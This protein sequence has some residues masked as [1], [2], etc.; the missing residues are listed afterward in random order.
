MSIHFTLSSNTRLNNW[1]PEL[2]ISALGELEANIWN[3]F[4]RNEMNDIF[5]RALACTCT[6]KSPWGQVMNKFSQEQEAEAQILSP[7][8]ALPRPPWR[9]LVL[10]C[11]GDTICWAPPLQ[12]KEQ[13]A[14]GLLCPPGWQSP[15]AGS[16][17]GAWGAQPP[18]ALSPVMQG[19]TQPCSPH[20]Q[21]GALATFATEEMSPWRLFLLAVA[22]LE[23][24]T[25]RRGWGMEKGTGEI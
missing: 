11:P 18:C 4:V 7:L 15:W 1:S 16:S 17:A 3:L 6:Y 19:S 14:S 5:S 25:G 20:R 8:A 9:S 2:I 22:T 12:G 21:W 13:S 23:V 10:R 24:K